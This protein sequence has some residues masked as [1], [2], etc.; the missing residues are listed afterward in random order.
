ML[1]GQKCVIAASLFNQFSEG[2]QMRV[3]KI[4]EEALS[5]S[6]EARALPADRLVES[7]DPAE[8]GYIDKLWAAE[9]NRRL[10]ELRSGQVTGIPGEEVFARLR[11]KYA[12]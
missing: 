11:Q 6:S 1:G 2:M 12:G 10:Q 4:A 8:D 7:L 9:G 3:E 5:L